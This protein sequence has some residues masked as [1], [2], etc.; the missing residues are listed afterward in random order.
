MRNR[1]GELYVAHPFSS[2]LCLGNFNSAAVAYYALV[3]DPLILSAVAFPVLHRSE[4]PLAEK[5]VSLRLESS[6]VDSL[7]LCYFAVGPF[8]NLFR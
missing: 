1:S 2:H 8:E 5:T 4:N 6:V 3:S 7:R